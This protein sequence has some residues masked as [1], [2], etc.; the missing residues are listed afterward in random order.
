MMGTSNY[1]LPLVLGTSSAKVPRDLNALSEAT[2]AT[3]KSEVQKIEGKFEEIK[4]LP[5][6]PDFLNFIKTGGPIFYAHRGASTSAP[7][8]T[9]PAFQLAGE[10][11]FAGIETDIWRTT[12]GVW[13]CMHDETV[14]RMTNG[15]G[16]TEALTSTYINSLTIDA[17]FNVALYDVLKVPTLQEYLTVCKTYSCTPVIEV[18][19]TNTIPYLSELI[20]I[21]KASGVYDTVQVEFG[22]QATATA[23]RQLDKK[24]ILHL[25]TGTTQASIDFIKTLGNTI[26][27]MVYTAA[28]EPVV[29]LFHQHGIP[30]STFGVSNMAHVNAQISNNVDIL[31]TDVHGG[32]T[33]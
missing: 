18:K 25:L 12:D 33:R 11:G 29:S 13:V 10:F 27:G 3:I 15:T 32:D 20:N 5:P 31:I 4:N 6:K 1:N 9:I 14:D 23:F 2:D 21:F 16:M 8:N 7:E 22:D 17:G 28:T 19:G 30:V 26:A 24:I